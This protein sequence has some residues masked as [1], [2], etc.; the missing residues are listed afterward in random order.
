MSYNSAVNGDW[1]KADYTKPP[2]VSGVANLTHDEVVYTKTTCEQIIADYQ[3]A[4][5]GQT[6]P[7]N[8]YVVP[9]YNKMDWEKCVNGD[10]Y[11][12]IKQYDP[13]VNTQGIDSNGIIPEPVIEQPTEEAP[14]QEV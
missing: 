14:P 6:P 1:S 11:A 8:E 5:N 3:A 10:T 7:D 9:T 2:W 13:N 4:N 12:V